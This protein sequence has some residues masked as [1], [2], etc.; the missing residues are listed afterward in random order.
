MLADEY[1]RILWRVFGAIAPSHSSKRHRPTVSALQRIGQLAGARSL[2]GF[3]W[4]PSVAVG[5]GEQRGRPHPLADY[6]E[7]WHPLPFHRLGTLPMPDEILTLAEV[8]Q[9]LKVADKTVY[10]MAQRGEVPAFKVRGQWRFKRDDLNEWIEQ[11]KANSRDEGR[12]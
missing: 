9:L 6:G 11:K 8:A 7:N 12:S 2:R 3:T 4:Q 1:R 10:T 5:A